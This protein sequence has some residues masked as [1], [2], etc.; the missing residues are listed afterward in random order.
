MRKWSRAFTLIELLVV[1]AI[2][3]LLVA[4]LLPALAEARLAALR[5][6]SL[7]NT[8]Q[9]GVA[10]NVYGNESKDSFPNPFGEGAQWTSVFMQV[11]GGNYQ[12]NFNNPAGWQTELFAAHWA[13][14]FGRYI[15]DNDNQLKTKIQFA[16]GDKTVYERFLAQG[17]QALVIWDGSYWLSPT[18]WF[19]PDKYNGVN[20]TVPSQ[21]LFRRNR[22]DNVVSPSAKAMVF[23][24]FDFGSKT[25]QLVNGGRE[26][27][28]P[29]FC[30]ISGKPGVAFVDGSVETVDM[31]KLNQRANDA[32]NQGNQDTFKPSGLWNVGSAGLAVYD[33]ANDGLEAGAG[34]QAW[35][36]YFWS[37]RKGIK[38]RD[39]P[40]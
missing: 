30:N 32:T 27:F 3:A 8:R 35:P 17:G 29:T 12:W 20:R 37:T 36:A 40:R 28:F 11:D 1:I 5:V 10:C 19:S 21:A 39:I 13:S 23:E 4:I 15:E 2:I 7:S 31:A 9:L 16:P 6:I 18:L 24:R 14:V 33:M 26:K 25:R 34:A 38:G 22:F